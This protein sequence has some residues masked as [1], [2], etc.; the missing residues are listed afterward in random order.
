[1][2]QVRR[3]PQRRRGADDRSRADHTGRA[4]TAPKLCDQYGIGIE[5]QLIACKTSI[6][7]IPSSQRSTRSTRPSRRRSAPSTTPGRVYQAVPRAKGEPSRPC[8]PP[9]ATP[10]SASTC[11]GDAKR[12]SALY[13]EYRKAPA[14]TRQR[15]YLETM[16]AP[17]TPRAQ[18]SSTRGAVRAPLALLDGGRRRCCSEEHHRRLVAFLALIL[19]WSSMFT[20]PRRSR[21]SSRSSARLWWAIS[22]PG[23]HFKLP[24]IRRPP[25]REGWLESEGD[26]NQIPTKDKKYIW[27]ETYARWRIRC[28]LPL[29]P[30][31]ARRAWRP[32]SLDDIIDGQTRN[33]VA[34][35]DLI[36]IVRSSNREFQ[37]TGECRHRRRRGHGPTSAPAA[38]RSPKQVLEKAPRSR[39]LLDRA[40]DC[41]SCAS[42][43]RESSARSSIA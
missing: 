33:A 34:L 31:R 25:L 27:V 32:E 39:G 11:R 35:L 20:S 41:A 36:E 19:V 43:R 26:P 7:P 8:A 21:P 12:F 40:E 16:G 23:L 6:P 28:P 3:R 42:L 37:I 1:M 9:R 10:W 4:A 24:L 15:L 22:A 30:E 29:L 13:A 2:R 38:R 17:A 14:V 5:V 18:V